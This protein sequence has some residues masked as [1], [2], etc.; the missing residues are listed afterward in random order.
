MNPET[1]VQNAIVKELNKRHILNWRIS[2][3][4]N[5]AGFPDLLVCYR[6]IFVALEVK[7]DYG[8]P[9]RQQELVMDKINTAGGYARIVRTVGNVRELL[10]D[11]DYQLS[12]NEVAV[13]EMEVG[14]RPGQ[15]WYD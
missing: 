9:T 14:R 13:D 15:T 8:E 6:G 7:T 2:G 4:S 12:K 10:D 5:M 11:I 3:A 1:A